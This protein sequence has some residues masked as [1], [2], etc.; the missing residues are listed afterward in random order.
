[1]VLGISGA[2]AAVNAGPAQAAHSKVS[3]SA[4]PVSPVLKG[5]QQG[6]VAIPGDTIHYV[7]GGSGPVLVLLH[8]WPMTWYEWNTVMPSL[9]KTHTVLAFDLPGLGDSTVPASGGY[10]TAATAVR[11]HQAVKALGFSRVSILSH[12][13]GVGVAYAYAA[14]YRHSVMRLGV[15]DSE[16]NGFGLENVYGVSFHFL[17]NMSASPTAE[18]IVNNRASER[19][20]LN[21]MF[22]FAHKPTAIT[23]AEKNAWYAAYAS[24]ANREAGFNY[25]RAFPLDEKWDIKHATTKLTIPVLAMGGQFSFGTGTATSM[26]GVDTD[27]HAVVAPGSGHYIPEED[28]GFLAECANLFFGSAK[29]PHAPAGFAACLPN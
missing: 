18:G 17:L 9:A 19:A 11:L 28:P 21:Y 27:V 23:Q 29:D 10:T 15:L 8:G 7:I 24:P 22:L 5:F 12:D 6:M 26:E 4:A 2:V 3:Q 20:Y 13:L 16:L 14:L 1:V 25:Y